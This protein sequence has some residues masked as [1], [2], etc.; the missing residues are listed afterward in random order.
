MHEYGI[1]NEVVHQILHACENNKIDYPKIISVE[2]GELTTYQKESVLFYFE[3]FKKNNDKLKEAILKIKMIK[4]KIKCNAC[5]KESI[6]KPM[7]LILCPKCSSL[8]TEV[9]DGNKIIIKEIN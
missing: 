1:T 2:L 9:L 7:P 3:S 8:D 4:G 6:V 5:K